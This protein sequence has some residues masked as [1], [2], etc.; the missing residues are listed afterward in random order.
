VKVPAHPVITSDDKITRIMN[1]GFKVGVFMGT[2]YMKFQDVKEEGKAGARIQK[3]Q[4][5][6]FQ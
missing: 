4:V 3:P 6:L 2:L 1:S 5:K